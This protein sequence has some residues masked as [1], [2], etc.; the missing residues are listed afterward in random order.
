[1]DYKSSNFF[2]PF[3]DLNKQSKN[4]KKYTFNDDYFNGGDHANGSGSNGSPSGGG[5]GKN[6]GDLSNGSDRNG[7]GDRSPS[8]SQHGSE[9]GMNDEDWPT[10]PSIDI[11]DS[12]KGY[13]MVSF[14]TTMC[15]PPIETP[16]ALAS[17]SPSQEGAN[18]EGKIGA[19]D[20]S[21]VC[22]NTD[23]IDS[24][25]AELQQQEKQAQQQPILVLPDSEPKLSEEQAR[26]ALLTH[27]ADHCCYGKAAAKNMHIKKME[28]FPAY[29]YELQ[30]FS[31]KRETAW[32]YAAI[33][34]GYTDLM[35][36]GP[37]GAVPPLPWEIV[38]Q[39]TQAFKDELRLV[40]VP[41]TGSTKQCHRC[42]GTGGMTCRDCNGKGW[43][44]CLNC[45]GDGWMHDSGGH[46]ERCFY[47]HHSKYGHGQLDCTKC[48]GGKGNLPLKRKSLIIGR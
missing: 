3:G 5:N 11:L 9:D 40:Q 31:E 36:G 17:S 34:P 45:H 41:N 33:R 39:P 6:N 2:D 35:G 42:R 32:T 46:R 48:K 16:L 43:S 4:R 30:T 37:L 27:I 21:G 44:R 25:T 19:E 38:E 23:G 47:C 15:P 28:C 14:D 1:M 7:D 18:Q 12:I 20:G 13:E 8:P 10:A 26:A 24:K 29:H 22:D